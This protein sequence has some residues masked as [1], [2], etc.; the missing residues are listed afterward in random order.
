MPGLP[1]VG[2]LGQDLA[3]TF[4]VGVSPEVDGN[5][6]GGDRFR[7]LNFSDRDI[8]TQRRNREPEFFGGLIRGVRFH[9]S[10]SIRDISACQVVCF[11]PISTPP[12][13]NRML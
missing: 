13:Q 10:D 11:V 6:S 2:D 7:W 5:V 3:D 9:I 1:A 4:D 12:S 8:R